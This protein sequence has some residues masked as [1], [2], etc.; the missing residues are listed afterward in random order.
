MTIARFLHKHPDVAKVRYPGLRSHS[1]HR[2]AKTIFG[3]RGFG[4]MITF[5]LARS[6]EE[7]VRFVEELAPHISHIGS[8]GDVTTSFLHVQAC[9]GDDYDASTIRLSVGV[10]SAGQIISCLE[11][12]LNDVTAMPRTAN[13]A[14]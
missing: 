12:A 5:D 2:L 10:E 9:F 7:S 8:L 13:G 4:A 6:E 14:S 3:R 1:D 11:K